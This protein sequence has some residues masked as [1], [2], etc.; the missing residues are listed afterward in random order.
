MCQW[1]LTGGV[2]SVAGK[3]WGGLGL[4]VED[5]SAQNHPMFLRSGSGSD[6]Q[7]SGLLRVRC[8]SIL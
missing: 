6:S 8:F 4:D 5:V 7:C 2:V 1:E 3:G